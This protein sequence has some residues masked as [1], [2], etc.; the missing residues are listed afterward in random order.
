MKTEELM[1][2]EYK[3]INKKEIEV[4]VS[5]DYDFL[6]KEL[7]KELVNNRY[8]TTITYTCSD[9]NTITETKEKRIQFRIQEFKN[10]LLNK[11]YYKRVLIERKKNWLFENIIYLDREFIEPVL[12]S[13]I[14]YNREFDYDDFYEMIKL[15]LIK[16]MSRK[17]EDLKY[18][19]FTS[20]ININEI[21]KQLKNND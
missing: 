3:H 19:T 10:N 2:V 5:I 20:K 14:I 21:K 16:K 18:F 12:S 8:F 13:N 11:T 9:S 17:Y 4:K 7:S 15:F 1:F 6:R